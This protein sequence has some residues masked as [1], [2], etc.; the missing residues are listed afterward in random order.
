MRRN[1]EKRQ[2]AR[3]PKSMKRPKPLLV[4]DVVRSKI[5]KGV[6][7]KGSTPNWSESL[8]IIQDRIESDGKN[9]RYRLGNENMNIQNDSQELTFLIFCHYKKWNY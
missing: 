9:T 4:G 1:T 3:K 7:D 5:S 2:E 8:F 6:L